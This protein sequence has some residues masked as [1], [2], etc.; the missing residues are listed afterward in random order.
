MM[1]SG[2]SPKSG[3]V[4]SAAKSVLRRFSFSSV[5]I[6]YRLP[7][8]I[9]TL[10]VAVLLASTWAAYRG[11]R[12]STTEV[13]R[14]RLRNLTQ[15]FATLSQQS[16]LIGLN[17]TSAVAN[18]PAIRTFLQSP[19]AAT[20]EA[21][22]KVLQQF[23]VAQDPNSMQVELWTADESLVL[24]V[25]ENLAPVPV[26][27]RAEFNAC[28]REPFKTPGPLR[29][30][31]DNVAGFYAAAVRDDHGT[32]IRYLVRWRKISL[33]PDPGRLKEF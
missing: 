17:R 8:F 29:A 30:V 1:S 7:L 13:G 18:D 33:N 19:S 25:P 12:N 10:L 3:L 14:E 27:L 26:S 15:Q 22:N 2:V 31:N 9:G 4:G 20:R 21:A 32:P 23:S 6:R 11:V 24:T 5:S 16:T 28:A